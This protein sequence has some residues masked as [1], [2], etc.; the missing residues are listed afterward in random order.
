MCKFTEYIHIQ[1]M[2]YSSKFY[3]E[4][5]KGITKNVPI[6]LDVTFDGKRMSYYTGKRC[7]IEQW[8]SYK[9]EFKNKA[10]PLNGQTS[11][12]F[13][14]DL[15][16]IKLAINDIF[17]DFEV[18][19]LI[20]TAK[21]LKDCLKLKLGKNVKSTD[22]DQFFDRFNFYDAQSASPS[23]FHGST[24]SIIKTIKKWR[25]DLN[26]YSLDVKCL[27]DLH[28]YLTGTLNYAENTASLCLSRLRSFINYSIN[29]GW[30]D[31]NPFSNY[32]IER[33]TYGEPVYL[34]IEERD[35]FFNTTFENEIYAAIR[36]IFILQ[37]LIG[38]RI[39][40]LQKMT[41]SNI[42][43]G[44]IEYIAG[45]TKDF[46]PIPAKVPLTQKALAIINRYNFSD[47]RLLP[48]YSTEYINIR[49]KKMFVIA[50][51]NR[52]VTIPDK[53]TR[54][55]KQVP[56]SS[57]ASTHMARRVF[58]G[59]LYKKGVK[60]SIICSMSGHVKGSSAFTRYFQIDNEDQKAAISLIE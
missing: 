51:L 21:Q 10:V 59:N 3:L 53:K 36:D 52:L 38:C 17:K 22:S 24:H 13:N 50:G 7:D 43:N 58:I 29:L 48:N 2:K 37:C 15:D 45:K 6:N 44:N 19:K 33:S 18:K 35:Q 55:S 30:T 20:P 11:A 60:D 1:K 32:K 9:N 25:P 31:K 49:L 23:R 16:R 12:D 5:R 54:I 14:S 26:Y 40:D 47:G 8:N 34:T 42:I 56:I 27:I 4:R 39:S 46:K 28:D 41:T 57:I